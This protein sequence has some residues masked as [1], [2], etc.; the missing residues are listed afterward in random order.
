MCGIA[1]TVS[2][3]GIP[4]RGLVA[5]MTRMLAHR[6]PDGDGLASDGPVIFGHRR[7]A[8]IDLSERGRQP[9]WDHR[10]RVLIT[11][12]GEI[13]NFPALRSE[14][15][16]HGAEF[17]SQSDTEVILEGYRL[18]GLDVFQRL[19]GMFA[20]ALWD[21]ELRRLVLARDRFGE[22]PLYWRRTPEGLA[23]ASELRPLRLDPRLEDRID[24]D[25]LKS[26]L[27]LG[28]VCG[29]PSILSGVH[30]LPPASYLVV[31][32]GREPVER[33]YWDLA[34]VANRGP[35]ARTLDH[36]AEELRHLLD[37]STSMRMVSD[38]PLGAFLSGGIDSASIVAA[39][40]ATAPGRQ[41]DTYSIGFEEAV[42][43]ESAEARRSAAALGATHHDEVARR[44]GGAALE[45]ILTIADEPFA[46]SSLI[47]TAQLA[48]FARRHSTVILSGDGGDE[49]FAGYVTY[50]ANELRR[51]VA[52]MP[53]LLKA[54]RSLVSLLPSD[55]GKVSF[56]YK[57]RRFLENAHLPFDRAHFAWRRI[58]DADLVDRL[59]G[60]A[61]ARDP[62]TPFAAAF[63][64]VR[65]AEPLTQAAYV[66]IKTWLVDDILVKVD[67]MAMA[68][69]LEVRAPFLDHRL[70]EFAFSLPAEL[71][72]KGAQQKRV[73]KASQRGRLPAEVL[74]RRKAGFNAP[75]S[76]W[77]EEFLSEPFER[78]VLSGPGRDLLDSGVAEGLRAQHRRRERDNGLILFALTVLGLWLERGR[79]T[80]AAAQAA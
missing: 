16:S 38:V 18:W 35:T 15:V 21:R 8:V 46:D 56:D 71:R 70:A 26:F 68:V 59:A 42:F 24:P 76:M 11:F 63:A 48:A 10:E 6:G 47:P 61:N 12:N 53:T 78:T 5:A 30:R 27:T 79:P 36:A 57:L 32:E 37:D 50:R 62:F 77:F 29:G 3:S 64:E 17:R 28:Y 66:D 55:H 7:L 49:L 4:D 39:M 13:Y 54:A 23:F 41:V 45:G 75:V 2:W 73:L 33:R 58:L 52:A 20:L 25:A 80:L 19:N 22:K 43:D 9:M 67:R 31:E 60:V 65:D 14:L 69:G 74:N 40:R 51:R 34:G 1:G 44:A 72:L